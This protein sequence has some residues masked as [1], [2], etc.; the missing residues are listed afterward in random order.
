VSE[1]EEETQ[2]ML[3]SKYKSWLS[4]LLISFSLLYPTTACELPQEQGWGCNPYNHQR[5]TCVVPAKNNGSDDTPAILDAFEKCGHEGHI[6]FQNTTY[7]VDQVMDITGLSDCQIDIYGTLLVSTA[8]EAA[9]ILKPD[10]STVEH[11]HNVLVGQ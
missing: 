7:Y 4:L 9:H 6:I 2:K 10:L 8:E 1:E 5:S 11:E 3:P